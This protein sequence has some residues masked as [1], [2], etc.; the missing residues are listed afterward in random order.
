VEEDGRSVQRL[1]EDV[2]KVVVWICERRENVVVA[3][4]SC[5][6]TDDRSCVLLALLM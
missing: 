4:V 6:L 3:D 1:G 2:A 5:L